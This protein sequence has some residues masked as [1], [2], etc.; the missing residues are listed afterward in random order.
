MIRNQPVVPTNNLA[1]QAAH[2][3]DVAIRATQRV[4]SGALDDLA[5]SVEGLRQEAAPLL[6][7]ANE[8]AHALAQRGMDAVRDGTHQV[9]ERALRASDATAAYIQH[10]PLK[11]VLIAAATGAALMALI[12]LMT[13]SHG[14]G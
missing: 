3:A 10:D 12:G 2:S 9:R 14:R 6:D 13:R 4:A 7:R 5:K 8:Q 1:D 11:S